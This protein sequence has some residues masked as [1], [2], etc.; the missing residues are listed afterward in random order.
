MALFS[1]LTGAQRSGELSR[2]S[3]GRQVIRRAHG[4]LTPPLVDVAHAA[5]SKGR[6][7]VIP[8]GSLATMLA[9]A[10]RPL[11]GAWLLAVGRRSL[12]CGLLVGCVLA[13]LADWADGVRWPGPLAAGLVVI[14]LVAW[15]LRATPRSEAVARFLDHTLDLKER[16]AT[17][18]ELETAPVAGT[19]FL[20]AALRREAAITL[21]TVSETWSVRARA[22]FG[23]WGA[24]LALLIVLALIVVAPWGTNSPTH[25]ATGVPSGAVAES[26][27]PVLPADTG[28]GSALSVRV[29][30]VSSPIP[31]VV[32]P[33]RSGAQQGTTLHAAAIHRVSPSQSTPRTHPGQP[34]GSS[35]HGG[36]SKDG[37]SQVASSS[38]PHTIPLVQGSESFL[39]TSPSAKDGKGGGFATTQ[40]RPGTTRSTTGGTGGTATAKGAP[41]SATGG[42]GGASQHQGSGGQ[43]AGSPGKQGSSPATA[44][45]CTLIYV[46]SRLSPSQLTTPGLI[47]GKGQFAGKGTPGGQTAGHMRGAAPT[48]GHGKSSSPAGRSKQLA[49]S[50][51]YGSNKAGNNS[52]RQVTGHN[53]AGSARQTIVT[54]GAATASV[55]DYVPPDANMVQPG[56]DSIVSLYFTSHSPS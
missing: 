51:P 44:G 2:A 3:P 49:I 47:T 50:S 37:H 20:G 19:S 24:A 22:A 27:P 5:P 10:S 21:R 17:A 43:G 55:I 25:L 48:G 29:A 38:P 34:A 31:A 9:F 6:S 33:A 11:R 54:A 40:A 23:E 18:L 45:S 14:G 4:W 41:G 26:A 1:P 30:V 12:L 53:G 35:S 13:L 36:N 15:S 28:G 32:A 42:K 7:Y 39:P 52:A 46:C 16:L 8:I 56:E